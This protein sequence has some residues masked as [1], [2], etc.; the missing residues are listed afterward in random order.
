M[1]PRVVVTHW[2]HPEVIALLEKRCD[3]V[4]N[5]MRETLPH[6]LIL[7][8][9]RDADA[10]LAFM[11]DRV[12]DAFLSACPR[13]RVVAG[14]LKGFDNFDADACNRRGV[15]LT[16]VPD[17]LSVPTAELAV[18]LALALGRRL[19]T[20]DATVR[21]GEFAGWRPILFGT[22]LA[23]STAGLIGLGALG[24]ALAR[25]LAAFDMRILYTDPR[26]VPPSERSG[27]QPVSFNDLLAQS[28]FVFPLVP[29][30]AET[31]HLIDAPA[32]KRMRPSSHLVNVCRGSVVDESAVACA[33]EDGRL[34]GYAA[35]VFEFEDW[36]RADRS[37]HI[38]ARLLSDADRTV[39]SPHLG[40]AVDA[41]RRAIALAAAESILDV[42]EG[43]SP[44][45]A[46]AGP[47]R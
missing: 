10:L 41:A 27:A 19:L 23:G 17:L 14:A 31:V 15:W 3:V 28:D 42:L 26:E 16:V 33:L 2:V 32:L 5:P 7:N 12:D 8:R 22:G 1:K 29:L 4:A 40:S 43:R 21:R 38:D 39:L 24:R 46:V 9:T 47:G 36:A 13:L 11:P 30:A 34:A 37:R 6:E 45:G 44:R 35:D 20:G 25:R 18:A